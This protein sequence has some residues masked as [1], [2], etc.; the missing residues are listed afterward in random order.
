MA[1]KGLSIPVFGKY[2][3]TD[4]TVT[5]SDPTVIDKLV[6]YGVSWSTGDDNPFYAD[7]GIAENDKGSFQSGELTLNTADLTQEV[8]AMIL[9]TVS[10]TETVTISGQSKSVSVQVY[11]DNMNPP[12]LGV[13]VVELHQINDVDRRRAVFFPKV[14]FNIPEEAATTKEEEIDWQTREITGIIQRSDA[15]T[16]DYVHPWM[17]DA[18]FDTEAEAV[19][20][21]KYMCG[22]T[23]TA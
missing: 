18:W 16:D 14:Y 9:G 8:S 1:I 10:K 12:Y 6:E 21:L 11:D 17:M 20:W 13:G 19:S 23:P 3:N 15:V 5:Y 7:N 2:N 4:G 22:E